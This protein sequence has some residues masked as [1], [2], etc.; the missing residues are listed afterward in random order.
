MTDV[1]IYNLG[2][3]QKLGTV[4]LRHAVKMLYRGVA[5]VIETVDGETFGPYD[6]PRAVELVRYVHSKWVYDRTRQV[7]YSKAALLR[8]DRHRCGYCG[9]TATTIDHVKPRCQGGQSTW[10]NT[11]AACRECN[12]RKA[13]RT[14]AEAGMRLTT[15]PFNPTL[16]DIYPK[17]GR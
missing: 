8:R 15:R 16:E 6:R 2:G 9:R 10:L 17:R 7:P 13:G 11:V 5:Q 14:P 3:T 12:A 4:S 1:V